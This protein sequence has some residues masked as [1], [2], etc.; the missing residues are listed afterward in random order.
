MQ[1]R[2]AGVVYSGLESLVNALVALGHTSPFY[3]CYKPTDTIADAIVLPVVVSATDQVEQLAQR[4][5]APVWAW[6]QAQHWAIAPKED[7][8]HWCLTRACADSADG[9]QRARF[10]ERYL[11][12]QPDQNLVQILSTK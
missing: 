9:Y 11:G 12:C 10:L 7:E 1:Y 6:L 3:I 5:H 8:A 4:L 2:Y